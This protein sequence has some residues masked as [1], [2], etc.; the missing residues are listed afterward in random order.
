MHTWLNLAWFLVRQ[1]LQVKQYKTKE[2]FGHA[3]IPLTKMEYMWLYRFIHH[4]HKFPC[5]DSEIFFSNSNKG[6]Y[7]H[8]LQAFQS[9]WKVLGLPGT[10]NVSLILSS[11]S[12]YVIFFFFKYL[13]KVEYYI[14]APHFMF[15]IVVGW[16][17]IGGTKK[18][19]CLP[20]GVPLQCHGREILWGRLELP[21]SFRNKEGHYLCNYQNLTKDNTDTEQ[22]N[23]SGE[24]QGD[25]DNDNDNDN[26][27]AL[28]GADPSTSRTAKQN[29]A[30][31]EEEKAGR[32]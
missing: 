14:F 18:G 29:Q 6:P 15:C 16:K 24:E 2:A 12:T 26:D 11:I 27:Q 31:K 25:T 7:H 28:D 17:I 20:P 9:C 4:R 21:R 5:G 13:S 3:Q 22:T 19:K 8:I 32:K 1:F 23:K 10:P 30:W